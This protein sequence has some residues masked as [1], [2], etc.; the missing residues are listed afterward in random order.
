[1]DGFARNA[2]LLFVA[3]RVGDFVSVA[4]GMWFVPRY[5]SPEDIG[6]VLPVSSFATF[7]S[8]PMFAFAMTV[9]KE[10]AGLSAAGRR[11]QVKTL[12][13]GVFVA[14]AAIM[15]AVLSASAVAAPHFLRAMRVSD[16]SVGFLVVAAAFLGCVAP[17]YTDALQSLRRFRALAAVEVAGSALRFCVMLCT[18]PLRAL[19]GYFAGQAALPAFRIAGSALALRRDLAVPAEP[20]WDRAA[21]RRMASAFLAIAI[22]QG[23]PMAA[24]L[25]EQ[26]LLRTRL[27]ALDS[28]GYYMVS[29]FS[30]FLHCLTLPLLLVMFP[31]TA[32]AAQR[33]GSTRPYV[34]GCSAV[35][36]AAAAAMATAYRFLGTPLLSLVPHGP[37]YAA[38]AP[39]MPWLVAITA[40][41]SCQVF[42]TNAEV[43]AGRFGFLAWLVPLHVLYSAALWAAAA[44]GWVA[45]LPTMLAWFGAASAARFAFAAAATLPRRRRKFRGDG[46]AA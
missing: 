31:Y 27:A 2:L 10:S 7:L 45:D 8:L 29:R 18:M 22:Y 36:L 39:C 38:Y 24:S 21:V 34:L 14:V 16:A 41:T 20:Y 23:V 19:A 28:A 44:K 15:L 17:V 32:A 37:D 42:Y 6:A 13:E 46:H 1:M 40:L 30:D 3:M 26:S 43:S 25:V 9:M 5:V 35:T 4:A 33:S 11:G 12:L